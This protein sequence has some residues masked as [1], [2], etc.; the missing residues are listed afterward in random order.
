MKDLLRF[1]LYVICACA[2]CAHA[3]S[4]VVVVP[5]GG[6]GDQVA[7]SVGQAAVGVAV[8]ET[9]SAEIGVQ[10]SYTLTVLGLEETPDMAGVTVK[11]YPNPTA[12]MLRV[13]VATDKAVEVEY[14][15]YTD[16][17]QLLE[18]KRF[19]PSMPIDIDMTDYPVGTYILRLSQGGV[20]GAGYQVIKK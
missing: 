5:A 6:D 13:D 19:D 17:G 11:V 18:S 9:G 1:S 7:V 10:Q 4:Q 3:A 8:G 15:L 2:S 12:S 14:G 16:N 20:V